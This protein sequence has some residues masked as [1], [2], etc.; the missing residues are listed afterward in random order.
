MW[1]FRYLIGLC[2]VRVECGFVGMGNRVIVYA[3]MIGAMAVT[4]C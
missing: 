3:G 2:R 1:N 4:P